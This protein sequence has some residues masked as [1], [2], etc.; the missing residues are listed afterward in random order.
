MAAHFVS[1]TSGMPAQIGG[2]LEQQD[3]TDDP[4]EARRPSEAVVADEVGVQ[5]PEH[6]NHAH[7]HGQ[8]PP[9]GGETC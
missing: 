6:D 9:T 5:L 3:V 1:E 4:T 8:R 2:H 7:W